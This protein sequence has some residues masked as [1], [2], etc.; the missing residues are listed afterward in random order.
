M[1]NPGEHLR[2][3]QYEALKNVPLKSTML[4]PMRFYAWAGCDGTIRRLWNR[5]ERQSESVPR[6][7]NNLDKLPTSKIK[8][9]SSPAP[10]KVFSRSTPEQILS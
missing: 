6:D 1:E 7:S 10:A 8:A 9:F 2:Y 4:A 3:N 5:R